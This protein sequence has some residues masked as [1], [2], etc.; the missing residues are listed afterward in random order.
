MGSFTEV[1]SFPDARAAFRSGAIPMDG[2]ITH[3]YSVEE[4][5]DALEAPRAERTAHK[6]V[7]TP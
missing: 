6:I 7:I 2:L 1:D 5:G 4:Y 3:R